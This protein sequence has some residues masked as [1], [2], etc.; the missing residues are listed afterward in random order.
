MM[1]D[2]VDALA[3]YRITKLILDDKITEDVRNVVFEKFPPHEH[4]LGYGSGHRSPKRNHQRVWRHTE[5]G[6]QDVFHE[7]P[8]DWRFLNPRTGTSVV[9]P[10]DEHSVR[11]RRGRLDKVLSLAEMGDYLNALEARHYPPGGSTWIA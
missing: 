11:E 3:T 7:R 2:V 8:Q 9:V 5:V 6:S 1:D 10:I 4:K